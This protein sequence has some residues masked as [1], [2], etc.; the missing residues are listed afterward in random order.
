M[1]GL[2]IDGY[3]NR[4]QT[5]E[6]KFVEISELNKKLTQKIYTMEKEIISMQDKNYCM[7]LRMIQEKEEREK[8]QIMLKQKGNQQNMEETEPTSQYNTATEEYE[9]LQTTYYI[10][11]KKQDK[12]NK[13]HPNQKNQH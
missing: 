13:N 10:P 2:A 8:L 4:Y 6:Q 12:S 3:N 11:Q 5:L 9:S 7:K 1:V